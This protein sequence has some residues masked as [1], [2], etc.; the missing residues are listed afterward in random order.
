MSLLSLADASRGP[1][2]PTV[3]VA[4]LAYVAENPSGN[5]DAGL[6]LNILLNSIKEFE[7]NYA[8]SPE[9]ISRWKMEHIKSQLIFLHEFQFVYC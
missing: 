7:K 8:N 1:E 9:I 6:S 4:T 5:E 3:S 2:H